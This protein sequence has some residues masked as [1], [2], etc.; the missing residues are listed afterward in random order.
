[1]CQP[2]QGHHKQKQ[3]K[4]S[5]QCRT[6][7]FCYTHSMYIARNSVIRVCVH[8]SRYFGVSQFSLFLISVFIFFII[9]TM[10]AF[11]LFFRP[12][13]KSAL[14]CI[15]SSRQTILCA[16]IYICAQKRLLIH[17]YIRSHFAHMLLIGNSVL[18]FT[19]IY[20]YVFNLWG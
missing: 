6:F 9:Y 12:T 7:T 14:T 5:K 3:K 17:I 4:T 13:L 10:V 15:C 16:Y 1:M 2:L 11:F 18:F 19:S 20:I 8:F